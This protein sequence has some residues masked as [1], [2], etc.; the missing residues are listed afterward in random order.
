[1]SSSSN[2]KLIE[3]E[4]EYCGA[5]MGVSIVSDEHFAKAVGHVTEHLTNHHDYETGLSA[6]QLNRVVAV[7]LCS[8][9][10]SSC[11]GRDI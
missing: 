11:S 8:R 3:C 4:C 1:M 6:G 10:C 5:P 9:V 2:L 7:K